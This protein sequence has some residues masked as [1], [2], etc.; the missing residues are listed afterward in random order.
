MTQPN[1]IEDYATIEAYCND[2]P[3]YAFGY[4]YVYGVS[5]D[6][7]EGVVLQDGNPIGRV[8]KVGGN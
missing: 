8:P 6:L 4:T 5:P 1:R 3:V 7:L 2:V